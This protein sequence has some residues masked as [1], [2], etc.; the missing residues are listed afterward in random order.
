MLRCFYADQKLGKNKIT[1]NETWKKQLW[2]YKMWLSENTK[3]IHLKFLK[4]D[5]LTL[6]VYLVELP[7]RITL[8]MCDLGLIP[9]TQN[10]GSSFWFSIVRTG[11][12]RRNS[13]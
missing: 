6:D 2:L 5:V 12:F 7:K 11:L 4:S 8:V 3:T 1:R 10:P 13:F 9:G